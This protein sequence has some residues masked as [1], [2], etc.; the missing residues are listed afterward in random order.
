MKDVRSGEHAVI[1]AGI[2]VKWVVEEDGTREA[3]VLRQKAKLIASDLLVDECANTFWKKVQRRELEGGSAARDALHFDDAVLRTDDGMT[4]RCTGRQVDEISEDS[5]AEGVMSN[6]A[7]ALM[8]VR[9]HSD[10]VK[11]Q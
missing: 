1:D 9:G 3:L 2:A 7:Q 4:T 8:L 10:D 6:L 11:D 5:V